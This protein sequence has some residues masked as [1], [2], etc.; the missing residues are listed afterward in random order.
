MAKPC[1]YGFL[2]FAGASSVWSTRA[3]SHR[4]DKGG[5]MNQLILIYYPP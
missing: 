3:E 4:N 2:I 1:S 5:W